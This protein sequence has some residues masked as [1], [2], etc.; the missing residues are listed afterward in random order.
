MASKDRDALIDAIITFPY[1]V[2]KLLSKIAVSNEIAE[3]HD[4][5]LYKGSGVVGEDPESGIISLCDL[6]VERTNS[7]W[8][9][10][11]VLSWLIET[12][13]DAVEIIEQGGA[14]VEK[15]A[16]F[17][18][19]YLNVPLNVQ[20][21]VYISEM[22]NVVPNL[23]ISN[24]SQRGFSSWDPVPPKDATRSAYDDYLEG[25]GENPFGGLIIL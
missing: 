12:V 21:H 20:R 16:K 15:T 1:F 3:T 2:S 18:Q 8:K 24:L 5:F 19:R 11:S 23:L 17:R 4:Y 25:R 10:P 14:R 22:N 9:D 7:L 6:Y 13:K